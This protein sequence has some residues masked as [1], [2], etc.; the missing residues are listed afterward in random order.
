MTV[1]LVGGGGVRCCV[2]RIDGPG[3]G[4]MSVSS[5]PDCVL[6]GALAGGGGGAS[7][8]GKFTDRCAIALPVNRKHEQ[9]PTA[10]MK[11]ARSAVS[12]IFITLISRIPP[13]RESHH[14]ARHGRHSP[15]VD[16]S[17]FSTPAACRL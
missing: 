17:S 7:A 3:S 6:G 14:R 2:L 4:M 13:G 11:K 9:N 12:R 5:P 10:S 15:R 1:R 16:K 8:G